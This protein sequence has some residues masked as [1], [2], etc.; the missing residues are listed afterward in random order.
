MPARGGSGGTA[1][2]DAKTAPAKTW[3]GGDSASVV[4]IRGDNAVAPNGTVT[5]VG[6]K[7]GESCWRSATRCSA[8]VRRNLPIADAR[9]HVIIPSVER[10]VKP[11]ERAA[12]ARLDDPG[13]P[14][15]DPLRRT[16][17]RR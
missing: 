15:G 5:W 2:G 17:A 9:V 10:S 4:L 1:V 7:Q 11:V 3:Q 12:R 16:S 6:G 8:P 13:P 14:G